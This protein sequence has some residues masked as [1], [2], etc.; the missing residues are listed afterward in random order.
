MRSRKT[1][2]LSIISVVAIVISFVFVYSPA[3]GLNAY[4]LK[5]GSGYSGPAPHPTPVPPWDR[6]TNTPAPTSTPRPTPTA[7]PTPTSKPTPTP[8][9]DLA[10]KVS[11]SIVGGP[12]L[13]YGKSY[14]L[15][16]SVSNLKP[17]SNVT[18]T[19][20]LY[21][22]YTSYNSTM[23]VSFTSTVKA[24][25]SGIVNLSSLTAL[26][27]ALALNTHSSG[28]YRANVSASQNGVYG[29]ANYYFY[30]KA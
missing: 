30:I 26:Q 6:P 13:K 29:S 17:G 12:A 20:K 19:V 23:V 5:G 14:K 22:Y 2:L 8:K 24:S 25:S 18:I 4:S 11:P 10:P 1:F 21:Y 27:R 15:G 9:P 28:N 3:P 7:K 16:G